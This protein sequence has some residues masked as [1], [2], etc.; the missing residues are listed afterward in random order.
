MY[1]YCKNLSDGYIINFG[2]RYEYSWLIFFCE[3]S[4][5]CFVFVV[6]Y[7]IFMCVFVLVLIYM[8]LYI[9]LRN[10]KLVLIKGILIF[11]IKIC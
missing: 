1:I 6:I 5:K 8:C 11:F 7:V 4:K 9:R 2:I 10:Y 3:F